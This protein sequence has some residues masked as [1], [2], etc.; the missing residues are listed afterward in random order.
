MT[1]R[2]GLRRAASGIWRLLPT[3]PR[4]ALAR[5][6]IRALSPRLADPLPASL[7]DGA[8]RIVAGFL[9]SA[10]GLGQ[11]ARLAYTAF[12]RAGRDV[13]GIDL[14]RF[15]V[16]AGAEIDFKFR[17]A[18]R[19]T[20]EGQVLV[21][22]NA[23]L[24]R[25]AASAMGSRFLKG[26]WVTGYWAWELPQMPQDWRDGLRF[27]HR[28]A[29]PSQFVADAISGLGW[30]EP[31]VVAPHPVAVEDWGDLPSR[32]TGPF[33]IVTAFNAASGFARK[34]PTALIAAFRRAFPSLASAA[35]LRILA[36]NIEHFPAGRAALVA[37]IEGDERIEL[38]VSP[39]LSRGDY[40]AWY[41][42]PDLFGSLHRSEGFGLGIAESMCRG[43]P[44]LAT[45]WSANAEYMD[46]SNGFPVAFSLTP[47]EDPQGKYREKAQV[48]ADADVIDAADRLRAAAEDPVGL[49]RVA[50]AALDKGRRQFS[51]FPL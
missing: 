50:A 28:L 38:L 31:V 16:A 35:R 41:G 24:M 30:L 6:A 4:Q 12:E 39:S 43:V 17:D 23:P 48:W 34:N 7:D 21:N 26:K 33:T 13:Y 10:S 19:L 45:N 5:V 20:G 47:V 32:P 1:A 15:L 51:A 44:A 37:A 46:E 11:A 18:A 14:S 27:A 36:T 42:A 22:V 49:A 40:L 2:D 9:T 8:P 29:A 25:L 3:G